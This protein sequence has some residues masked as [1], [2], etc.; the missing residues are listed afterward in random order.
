MSCKFSWSSSRSSGGFDLSHLALIFAAKPTSFHY[1]FCLKSGFL[2]C[3]NSFLSRLILCW[4]TISGDSFKG[5]VEPTKG[6]R[7]RKS[8]L[9][10]VQALSYPSKNKSLVELFIHECPIEMN[11]SCIAWL[12]ML[13]LFLPLLVLCILTWTNNWA[14]KCHKKR[15]DFCCQSFY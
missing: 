8:P 6:L 9:S 14:F 10:K 3:T 1:A 15:F 11:A 2:W 5:S 13:L 7:F 12:F 4:K